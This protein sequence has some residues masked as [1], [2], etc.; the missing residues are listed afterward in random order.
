M[1]IFYFALVK[2]ALFFLDECI[3]FV[4]SIP[5]KYKKLL[6]ISPD[7]IGKRKEKA[8]EDLRLHGDMVEV[9]Q[10]DQNCALLGGQ[11]GSA[12]LFNTLPVI[13]PHQGQG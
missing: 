4:Y 3:L 13:Q 2:I 5:L 8:Q 12:V 7:W 10:A 6:E 1:V 9:H 11:R